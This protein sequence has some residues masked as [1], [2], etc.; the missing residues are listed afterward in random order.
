MGLGI[1]NCCALQYQR[2]PP[3]G[4]TRKN[5]NRNVSTSMRL[6]YWLFEK[7]EM[8]KLFCYIYCLK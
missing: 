5:Q 4:G 2:V 6:C 8:P 1:G 7:I 3:N